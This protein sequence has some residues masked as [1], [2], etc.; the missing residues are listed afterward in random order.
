MG[1]HDGGGGGDEDDD[2]DAKA[3]DDDP[4]AHVETERRGGRRVSALRLS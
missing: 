1:P 2:E 4:G 3:E